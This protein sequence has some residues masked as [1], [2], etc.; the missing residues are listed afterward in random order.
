[1]IGLLVMLGTLLVFRSVHILFQIT[2]LYQSSFA[3][4]I[5]LVG[6]SWSLGAVCHSFSASLEGFQR[7]DLWNR[8]WITYNFIRSTGCG[9]LLLLGYGLV[10]LGVMV[11]SS[12]ILLYVLN[13]RNFRRVVPGYHFDVHGAKFS[14]FAQLARYG[15]HTFLANTS[16][17][18]VSQGPAVLIGHFLPTAYVGYYSVP[19]RL[20]QV[21]ITATDSV[22]SVSGSNAAELM[23]KDEMGKVPLLGLLVNRYCLA[24]FMPIAAILWIY[25][26]EVIQTWIRKSAYVAHSAP[27]LPILLL[28]AVWV[29]VGQV[30]TAPILY[31]LGKHR[32]YA[33]GLLVEAC[34]SAAALIYTIPRHG[35]IGAVSVVMGLMILNRGI[36][37]PW[38]LCHVL[39]F[40]YA[41]YMAG[42][43]TRPLLTAVPLIAVIYLLK[44]AL[45]PGQSFLEIIVA[46]MVAG[47][48]GWG[49]SFFT[50]LQQEHRS[51]LL[52]LVTGFPARLVALFR[53][54][55]AS[56]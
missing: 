50:V 4:L 21:S 56:A 14:M 53:R 23:A 30:N 42:I 6:F 8:A 27:L 48:L 3:K 37:T 17:L 5:L 31:G 34:L 24:V 44:A 20:I 16:W 33:R 12:Q 15:K 7:F 28:G 55:P 25:R 39:R 9:V 36:Y 32:G 51:L 11:V 43:Y 47:V 13:Y 18:V 40:P 1:L 52:Q 41:R 49:L 29:L 46:S 54:Q 19:A 26:N 22:I 2:P 10:P 35:I 45:V 38:Y